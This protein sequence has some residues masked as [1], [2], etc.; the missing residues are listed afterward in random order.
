MRVCI[1]LSIF[2]SV[3]LAQEPID[4]LF[5]TLKKV[6]EIDRKDEETL[7]I[8]YNANMVVGYQSTP[9]ARVA[10]SG[11]V[12]IG[13]NYLPPYYTFGANLQLYQPIELALNYRVFNNRPEE[14]FGYQG[15]GDDADRMAHVKFAFSFPNLENFNLPDVAVGFDDF[16]GSRR[17]YS[18]YVVGTQLIEPW[19]LELSGGWGKGRM[20]GFFGAVAWSPWRMSDTFFLKDFSFFAEYDPIDYANHP[21]EHPEGREVKS[22]VNVGVSWDILNAIQLKVSTLRGNDWSASAGLHYNFGESKGWLPKVKD[23]LIYSSP[24][25]HEPI[26]PHRNE[27]EVAYQIVSALGKQGLNVTRVYLE[28][29]KV[30]TIQLINLR[31]FKS[32][33]AR[34]R[35]QSVLASLI[36]ENI[37]KVIVLL[38]EGSLVAQSYVFYQ[39][40]L[41]DYQKGEL[42]DEQMKVLSPPVSVKPTEYDAALLFKRNKPVWSLLARPRLLSFFGSTSGKYKYAL[43]LIGGPQGY[44]FDSIYYKMQ[45][46]YNI[47]SSHQKVGDI[48]VYNPSQLLNV[49]SD[50]INYYKSK[51]VTL[52]K[53]YL[54]SA[55]NLGK[56]WYGR[57]AA[58]YFEPAYAGVGTE[59][60]FYPVG[61]NWALGFEAA[62]VMK[63]QYEGLGFQYK[64]RKLDGMT[65]VYVPFVGFQAFIDYYYDFK[66]LSLDFKVQMGQFLARDRGVKL[67]VSRYFES[68]FRVSLWY[69]ATDAND[70]I[71]HKVYH[72]KGIAFSIPFDFFLQKSSR[73]QVGYGMSFW[74]RDSGAQAA[75]GKPLYPILNG[76]RIYN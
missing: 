42:N 48:D 55:G 47:A 33:D 58:G 19:S 72:D 45:L 69:A 49:R 28:K 13:A 23:P 2:G 15:F 66:P 25:D 50:S 70:T 51:S 22:R 26:G 20:K 1:L 9:S 6:K 61:S 11:T 75:T 53:A 73:A 18:L 40:E 35:I 65:P 7:P 27:K 10:P 52:E 44:L 63:R 12:Y 30:L 32:K 64:V 8:I 37:E 59:A 41:V 56:G 31:Y 3:L 14:N 16:Y 62:C 71:N 57:V 4:E 76:A 74:Q 36:P 54:Q 24:V 5:E 39:K 67:T 60:L 17:F 46:A 43:G 34:L 29:D 38:E 21:D 68:G